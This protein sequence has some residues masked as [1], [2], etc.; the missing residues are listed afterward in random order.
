VTIRPLLSVCAVP[1]CASLRLRLPLPSEDDDDGGIIRMRCVATA[2]FQTCSPSPVGRAPAPDA[3]PSASCRVD[4]APPVRHRHRLL[5]VARRGAL[6]VDVA[7]RRSPPTSS[8]RVV[9]AYPRASALCSFPVRARAKLSITYLDR[10]L[11]WTRPCYRHRCRAIQKRQ[12]AYAP[13]Q[14]RRDARCQPWLAMS[15]VYDEQVA[16]A[17]ISQQ[18]CRQQ[19]A[20]RRRR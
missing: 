11:R 2:K 15:I 7:A 5:G 16:L 4:R 10:L 17:C 8:C 9:A 20:R 6:H 12:L 3:S 13:L 19:L 1:R 18:Q 14:R